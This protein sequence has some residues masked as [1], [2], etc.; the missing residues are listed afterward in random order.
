MRP[1]NLVGQVACFVVQ[2]PKTVWFSGFFMDGIRLRM[3]AVCFPLPRIFFRGAFL[4]PI[5]S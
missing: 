5:R 4:F 1:T 2:A 3:V